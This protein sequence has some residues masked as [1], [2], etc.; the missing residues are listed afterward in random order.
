MRFQFP[1]FPPHSDIQLIMLF[2]A[3]LVRTGGLYVVERE[4]LRYPDFP[5]HSDFQLI[6]FIS[7]SLVRMAGYSWGLVEPDRP[8]PQLK[9]QIHPAQRIKIQDRRCVT[10]L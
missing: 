9:N 7:A 1:D 3:S 10:V 4:R 2:S 5:P 8:N 6:M